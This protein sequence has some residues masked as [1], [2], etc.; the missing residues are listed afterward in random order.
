VNT[1]LYERDVHFAP[2]CCYTLPELHSR[3]YSLQF[4]QQ[5]SGHWWLLS[6]LEAPLEIHL[7]TVA[8]KN[9]HVVMTTLETSHSRLRCL[10]CIVH[11][12][13]ENDH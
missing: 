6:R 9:V 7:T 5:Q 10:L 1:R 3:M 11:S 4:G 2:R 8:K 12:L 13:S